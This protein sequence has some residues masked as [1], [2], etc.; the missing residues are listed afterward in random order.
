MGEITENCKIAVL[1]RMRFNNNNNKNNNNNDSEHYNICMLK[2]II[3]F[4]MISGGEGQVK[5]RA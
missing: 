5:L 1:S 2:F 3:A 4:N